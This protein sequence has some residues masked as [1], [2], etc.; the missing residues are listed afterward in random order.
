MELVIKERGPVTKLVIGGKVERVRRKEEDHA[1]SSSNENRVSYCLW[2]RDNPSQCLSLILVVYIH[3]QL[4]IINTSGVY[5]H[6]A[7]YHY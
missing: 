2:K 5:T 6:A 3:I 7:P 4:P 1:E